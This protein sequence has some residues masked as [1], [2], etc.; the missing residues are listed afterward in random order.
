MKMAKVKIKELR[1]R[2]FR[3]F[4]NARFVLDDKLTVVIGRNGSGKSTLME[5]FDFIRDALSDS[6]VN[7][8]ARHGRL[9]GISH[10]KFFASGLFI[11]DFSLAIVL[12]V[13]ERE[14]VYGFTV[15]AGAI[16]LPVSSR[17]LN[18]FEV[19]EEILSTADN[20]H[21]FHRKLD[22]FSTDVTSIA[23]ALSEEAL[24]L[25]LVASQ[26]DT[27]KVVWE[28]LRGILT[29]NFSSP[30]MRLEP[31]LGS[32]IWLAKD[33]SNIGDALEQLY[34]SDTHNENRDWIVR[35]LESITPGIVDVKALTSNL[36]RR[37]IQF[38]QKADGYSANFTAD[39]MSDGTLR[40]LG[41]LLALRQKPTPTLV[42]IDEIEDSIDPGALGVILDAISASTDRMQVV[43]SSHNT[44]LLD[45]KMIKAESTRVVEW[46]EGVSSIHQLS[47]RVIK[48]I[49][50]PYA[51]TLKRGEVPYSVGELL[52]VNALRTDEA[53][54]AVVGDFFEV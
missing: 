7:A 13:D 12:T 31:V 22:K 3:A 27:W 30:A 15:G 49:D 1:L 41:I 2:N 20:V 50:G 9:V 21:F 54:V 24:I 18:V 10:R 4:E 38:S 14:I 34:S 45:R 52:R 35:H 40:A 44:D 28:A 16:S 29:Y 36:G 37:T 26:S 11:R 47:E 46:Q 43:I 32:A 23:P 8:L 53:P 48:A 42:L 39:E 33:G 51:G 19:K 17:G 6:L 5:A 25:P